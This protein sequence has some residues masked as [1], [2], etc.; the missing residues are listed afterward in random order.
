MA[1]DGPGLPPAPA[2]FVLVRNSGIEPDQEAMLA[3]V[4]NDG[5]DDDEM[6]MVGLTAYR[7]EKKNKQEEDEEEERGKRQRKNLTHSD[8]V[9]MAS[10]DW[11]MS[12]PCTAIL[13]A[14][15]EDRKKERK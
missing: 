11:S 2:P 4:R 8:F 12:G 5:D 3:E 13:G 7:Q 6:M 15:Q 14:K 1:H 10:D 9:I